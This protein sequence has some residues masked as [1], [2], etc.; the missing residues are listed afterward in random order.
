M[1]SK[2]FGP[3]EEIGTGADKFDVA[4]FGADFAYTMDSGQNGELQFET[5]NT[6][7][8][9]HTIE[10]KALRRVLQ[11]TMINAIQLAIDFQNALPQDEVPEKNREVRKVLSLVAH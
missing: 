1:K 4:Q 11:N 8:R 9:N 6:N 2:S 10:G 3:D 5:F 7:K